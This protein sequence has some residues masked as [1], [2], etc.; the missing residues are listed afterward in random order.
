[1]MVQT[2]RDYFQLKA[3]E[4]SDWFI[5]ETFAL[6][7]AMRERCER[8]ALFERVAAVAAEAPEDNYWILKPSDGLKGNRIKVF[9]GIDDI[10]EHVDS[11]GPDSVA[12][13]ASRYLHNPALVEGGRKFD[14]RCWVLLNK[15]YDMFLY[16]EGVLRASAPPYSLDDISDS[17]AHLSNHCIAV[18]HPDFG[19]YEPTNEIWF[20]DYDEYLL[21]TTEG[22]VGFYRDIYTQMA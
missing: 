13:V 22:R 7:P 2:L 8:E 11:L 16:K 9:K 6:Y 10:K 14:V 1:M 20:N 18:N 15:D 12:W 4:P 3:M 5:P 19:K 21:R 17:Y